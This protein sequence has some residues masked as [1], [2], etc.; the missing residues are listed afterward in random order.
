MKEKKRI[1]QITHDLSIGGLQ[2]VVVNL[3]RTIDRTRFDISVL[4]LRSSGV[5]ASEIEK[6]GITVFCLPQTKKTDY[7]AFLK[8]ADLLR[9]E[10]IDIIHTHNTQPLIDGTLGA[11]LAG[12]PRIIHTDH[13][14]KFPDKK[15]YMFAEKIM[16][17]FIHKY[18]GVSEQ[19]TRDVINFEKISPRKTTTIINGID[20]RQFDITINSVNK[21]KELNIT[22]SGPVIGVVAR[23][24]EVKGVQYLIK[25]MP[26][27]IEKIS[28]AVLVIVGDGPLGD[29]L[30]D[31]VLRLGIEGNVVFTGARL[32]TPELFKIFDL[33]VLPSESEGLPMVLLE[34]M[35]SCCPIIAADVGGVSTVIQHKEN[36]FLIAPGMPDLIAQSV[37]NLLL[38]KEEK[39]KYAESGLV[40]FMKR[41]RAEIMTQ[42]YEQLYLS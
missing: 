29:K 22:S 23:L 12:V 7:F 18:V 9:K 34:A 5:L 16:S 36:G 2:Q 37:I 11:L 3:C 24:S 30:K 8:I 33:Y 14:R 42:H 39:K 27:I 38:N 1:M 41:F 25:A 21:K 15:K 4:C 20:Y 28:D 26:A 35:A 19:T 31:D 32:D 13:G 40:I 10:K 6:M 17:L